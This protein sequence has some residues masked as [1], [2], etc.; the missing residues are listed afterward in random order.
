MKK[1]EKNLKFTVHEIILD[2]QENTVCSS[3]EENG[4]PRRREQTTPMKMEQG[5]DS[6]YPVASTG[7]VLYCITFLLL[8][9]S[10]KLRYFSI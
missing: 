4:W 6:L 3:A 5:L 9:D 10:F 7:L 2:L 8:T 1:Y